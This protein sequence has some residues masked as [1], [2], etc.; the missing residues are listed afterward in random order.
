MTLERM[1]MADDDPI[2][3]LMAASMIRD[4]AP[5]LYEMAMEAYRAVKSG[6]VAAVQRESTR[7]RRFSEVALHGPF[8]EE[9]GIGGREAVIF[10]IDR[11]LQHLLATN[12][13][14]GQEPRQVS[15]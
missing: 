4:D 7:L 15:S 14:S 9:L 8:M 3:I 5:W 1:L 6:D 10:F 13:A 12:R 11:M 2:G